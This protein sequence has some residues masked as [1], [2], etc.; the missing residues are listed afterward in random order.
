MANLTLAIDD[1]LLRS[2]RVKA[3]Q[4]GTSVNDV[5]REAIERFASD[6]SGDDF[7]RELRAVSARGRRRAAADAAS[8]EA[9]PPSRQALMDEALQQRLPSLLGP[10]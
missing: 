1:E 10:R 2:A 4:L 8:A 9:R 5:C 3:V 7:L 6:G